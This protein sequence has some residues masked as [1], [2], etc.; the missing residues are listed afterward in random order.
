MHVLFIQ[1]KIDSCVETDL[2]NI[3]DIIPCHCS[4]WEYE[5]DMINL[6]LYD[7]IAYGYHAYKIDLHK[8]FPKEIPRFVWTASPRFFTDTSDLVISKLDYMWHDELPRLARQL[9]N[10]VNV[11]NIVNKF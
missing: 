2:K 11:K 9:H 7:C 10:L 4:V 6:D 8:T 5:N 1:T 3:H